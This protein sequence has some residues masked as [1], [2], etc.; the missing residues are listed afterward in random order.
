MTVSCQVA[1]PISMHRYKSRPALAGSLGSLG[2]HNGGYGG[3]LHGHHHHHHQHL[4]FQAEGGVNNGAKIG[5]GSNTNITGSHNNNNNNNNDA[6]I[7]ELSNKTTPVV[8]GLPVSVEG[9]VPRL[10]ATRRCLQYLRA[11]AGSYTAG[12]W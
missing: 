12:Q 1:I 8:V 5:G 2:Q 10:W 11:A 6:G 4:H 9:A 7:D 3:H